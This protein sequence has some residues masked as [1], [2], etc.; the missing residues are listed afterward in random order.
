M[1]AICNRADRRD[2]V[3]H[4]LGLPDDPDSTRYLWIPATASDPDV[5]PRENRLLLAIAD[6]ARWR[7]ELTKA[8]DAARCDSDHAVSATGPSGHPGEAA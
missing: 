8:Q 3:R 5:L 6:R 4:L 1:G 7:D 2:W